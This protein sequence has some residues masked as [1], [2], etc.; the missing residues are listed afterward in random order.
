MSALAIDFQKERLTSLETKAIAHK[1]NALEEWRLFVATALEIQASGLYEGNW[2]SYCRKTFKLS[3][4]RI[5]QYKAAVPYAE[6]IEQTTGYQPTENQIRNLR[7]AVEDESKLIEVYRQAASLYEGE[8][9]KRHFQVIADVLEQVETKNAVTVDGKSVGVTPVTVDAAMKEAC[10]EADMRFKQ[11]KTNLGI[12]YRRVTKQV[13]QAILA[14]LQ[15]ETEELPQLGDEIVF[16][17]K[18]QS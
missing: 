12:S 18:G 5:R 11:H 3:A 6:L 4:T 7:E 1:E 9:A 16:S 14:I 2:E 10:I 15:D 13:N 17:W 8:P